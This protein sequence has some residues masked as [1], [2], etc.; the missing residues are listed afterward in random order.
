[1][2]IANLKSVIYHI[3]STKREGR[4]LTYSAIVSVTTGLLTNKPRFA[5][6]HFEF[7]AEDS[8][9]AKRKLLAESRKYLKKFRPTR[10]RFV[11]IAC[12]PS[13]AGRDKLL[14]NRMKFSSIPALMR[15]GAEKI[16]VEGYGSK[17]WNEV[18]GQSRK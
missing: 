17:Q 16:F 2:T 4:M 8:T 15:T 3:F 9:K 14:R 5:A 18:V 6:K 10:G 11:Q 12:E 7:Q 13:S 1:M